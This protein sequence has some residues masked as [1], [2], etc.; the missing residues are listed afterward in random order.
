MEKR[1]IASKNLGNTIIR[2]REW[3]GCV[4]GRGSELKSH[5]SVNG[6]SVYKALKLMEVCFF[7]HRFRNPG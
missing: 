6:V 3:G 1:F 2:M 4:R 7:R 5:A